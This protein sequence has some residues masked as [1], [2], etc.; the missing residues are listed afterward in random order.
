M[1]LDLQRF[2]H[3]S[4]MIRK[5][6]FKIFGDSFHIYDPNDQ[7]VLYTKLK[8]FK[9]KED[10]RLY[11]S[12]AMERELLTIRARQVIDFGATYDVIDPTVNQRVGCLRRKGLKSLLR[13]EWLVMDGDE[14]EIGL[15]QEDSTLKAIFRRLLDDWAFLFPQRYHVNIGGQEVLHARQRFNPLIQKIDL[16]FSGNEELLDRRLGLA[17]GVLLSAVE[18]RQA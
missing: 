16:T 13:D 8:A 15:V 17:I 18:G 1:D 9:L 6:F 5:K 2:A 14:R 7:L 10:I 11:A 3:P 12:E 4:Y